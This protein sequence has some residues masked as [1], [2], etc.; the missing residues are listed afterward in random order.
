VSESDE[1]KKQKEL[2]IR[3]LQSQEKHFARDGTLKKGHVARWARAA[4]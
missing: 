1:M 4:H 3:A 2:N